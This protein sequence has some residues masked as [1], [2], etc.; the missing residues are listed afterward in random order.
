MPFASFREYFPEVAER[1][2]RSITVLPGSG[3][4]LPPDD[5]GFLEMYCNEPGC[6]CRRVLFYVVAR[7]RPDVQAVIGW[8][9]EDVDFY[10]RWMKSGDKAQAARVK[11]PALNPLSPATELAPALMKLV[12]DVLLKDPAYVERIKRHYRMVRETVDRPRRPKRRKPKK[13]R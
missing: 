2:V 9:W 10:A 3:G 8:G 4:D 7:S 1:E 12:R 13:R 6:D 5:Y 11:G